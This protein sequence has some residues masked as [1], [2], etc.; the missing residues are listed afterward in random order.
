MSAHLSPRWTAITVTVC[1]ALLLMIVI[2]W[3]KR[4]TLYSSVSAYKNLSTT[5][6]SEKI[7]K[8]PEV[9]ANQLPVIN[10]V[11][12]VEIHG[13][14]FTESTQPGEY[15]DLQFAVKNNSSQPLVAF[16]V[17]FAITYLQH[18]GIEGTAI[19][20][21]TVN[22]R[23]HPDISDIHHQQPF[24]TGQEKEFGP[25][26]VRLNN[27]F[28]WE[29][30]KITLSLDYV[31]FQDGTSLGP[32]KHGLYSVGQVREGAAKYK[33][34]LVKRFKEGGNSID[35]ILPLLQ[36]EQLPEDWPTV[37]DHRLTGARLYRSHMLQ[38]IEQHGASAVEKYFK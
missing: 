4:F 5:A 26:P 10:A 9:V 27:D 8:A 22:Q 23:I 36:S 17:V 21:R 14:K 13:M 16:V 6:I 20:Y 29:M 33:E 7:S 12:P 38:A 2:V 32:N 28:H 11:I 18:D 34:W 25:E 1:M 19:M 37:K 15:G 30:K 31:D 3:S 24:T 35:A